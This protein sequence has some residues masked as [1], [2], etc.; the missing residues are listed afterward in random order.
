[1]G[2]EFK[3]LKAI[4]TISATA[5]ELAAVDTLI[6]GEIG[7]ADFLDEYTSLLLDILNTYRG[8]ETILQPVLAF[9]SQEAFTQGFGASA[10]WYENHYQAALSEARANAELTFHKYLQFRKRREVGTSFPLLKQAFARLHEYIDKW[11]DND[12]WLAMNIDTLLKTL[13]LLVGEVKSLHARDP[14]EA[15]A[16]YRASV[17]G[18]APYLEL[19]SQTTAGIEP[20]HLPVKQTL[21]ITR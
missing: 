15:F 12:I 21:S 7:S 17:A 18:L 16:V 2:N 20:A 8:L 3:E 11:I 1:M 6:T 9:H 19:I 13:F 10:E 5:V 14:E 4:A